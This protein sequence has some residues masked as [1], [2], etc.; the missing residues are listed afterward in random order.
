MIC[1]LTELPRRVWIFRWQPN[2]HRRPFVLGLYD[3][4]NC[5]LG[6]NSCLFITITFHDHL[7]NSEFSLDE[8]HFGFDISPYK[9]VD[10]WYQRMTEIPGFEE[11]DAGAREFGAIVTARISN[12]FDKLWIYVRLLMLLWLGW[13]SIN[14]HIIGK[15]GFVA[16]IWP[17]IGLRFAVVIRIVF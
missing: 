13:P 12:S 9:Y 11:C 14:F 15:Q 17:E 1:L 10:S 16:T 4:F 5:E 2:H 8:Q 3:N 7:N 6:R